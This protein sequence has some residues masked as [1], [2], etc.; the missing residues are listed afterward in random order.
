MTKGIRK[1]HEEFVNEINSKFGDIYE[2]LTVYKNQNIDIIV[3]H[4]KCN[5]TFTSTPKTLLKGNKRNG[6][7]CPKCSN[8]IRYDTDSFKEKVYELTGNEY[9]II[10]NYINNHTPI[11]MQHNTEF[12]HHQY[13]V[14]PKDFLGKHS[15]CPECFGTKKKTTEEFKQIVYD[16]VGEEIIVLGEYINNST[17]ILM[18]HNIEWCNHEFTISPT[19]FMQVDYK[20]P[21]CYWNRIVTKENY[22]DKIYEKYGNKYIP[23][24]EYINSKTPILFKHNIDTCGK[25]FYRY[26]YNFYYDESLC[27]CMKPFSKAEDK[28]LQYIV[29][30]EINH[31]K[32]YSFDDCTDI[33]PLPFDFAILDKQNTLVNLI[34]CDGQQHFFPVD[35]AGKGEEWAKER[36]IETKKHDQ[37]KNQY[38]IDNDIKLYR[39][40]YWKF[41]NIEEIL[42]KLLHNEHI[43]LDDNFIVI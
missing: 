31:K 21:K 38:C 16:L 3:K 14:N 5:H 24:T 37:I 29:N 27:S 39:I 12:C 7:V 6:F 9:V 26:L 20:C 13:P 40:P 10:G 17:E 36:F 34:E 11:L 18:K 1:T 30:C 42:N 28:A 22:K 8:V 4:K 43:E 33:N 25:V 2:F 35:F 32:Q 41:D 15:R 23:I 19:L